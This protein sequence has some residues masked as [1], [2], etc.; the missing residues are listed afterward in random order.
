MEQ[1]C[2]SVGARSLSDFAR[3]ATRRMLAAQEEDGVFALQERL[4]LIDSHLERLC[5]TLEKPNAR[6][7]D[8]RPK[9][10]ETRLSSDD[11][12]ATA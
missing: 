7:E 4:R 1:A 12:S 8:S 3:M 2:E 10:A 6:F 5:S 9:G 11:E